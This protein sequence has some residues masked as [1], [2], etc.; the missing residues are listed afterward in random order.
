MSD[1]ITIHG[2][3]HCGDVTFEAKANPSR[4]VICHCTDCQKMSGGPYRSIVQVKEA[5]FTLL[6]GEP[7]L[8]FKVGDSGNRRELSFCVNCGSHLYATSV[9]EDVPRGQRMLGIRTGLLDELAQLAPRSQVWC[10]SKVAWAENIA[11][12]PGVAQQS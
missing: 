1:P 12:L 8:Y 10:Q 7:K 11:E 4:V 2:S 9:V 3:C 6:S 5:D